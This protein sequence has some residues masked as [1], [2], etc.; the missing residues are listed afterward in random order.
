MDGIAPEMP[1]PAEAKWLRKT[2]KLLLLGVVAY[3]AWQ[4]RESFE[5]KA[6]VVYGPDHEQPTTLEEVPMVEQ[7][8]NLIRHHAPMLADAMFEPVKPVEPPLPVVPTLLRFETSLTIGTKFTMSQSF[9]CDGEHFEHCK[10]A[11][12]SINAMIEELYS[13]VDDA[14]SIP[15]EVLWQA[16]Y[17]RTI[18]AVSSISYWLA[19]VFLGC[20]GLLLS[21][22][23]F[24]LMIV[25]SQ[26][27][28]A[29]LTIWVTYL[30]IR[31]MI[32]VS[33]W[34][35]KC[36][37]RKSVPTYQ[38]AFF[39]PNAI[40][41]LFGQGRP[42]TRE[43]IH[44]GLCEWAMVETP[45]GYYLRPLHEIMLSLHKMLPVEQQ[46]TPP[47]EVI[48]AGQWKIARF[49]ESIPE[50]LAAWLKQDVEESVLQLM[51]PQYIGHR[52]FARSATPLDRAQIMSPY[53]DDSDWTTFVKMVK[54]NFFGATQDS[55]EIRCPLV[56]RSGLE[57]AVRKFGRTFQSDRFPRDLTPEE[58][59]LAAM[60]WFIVRDAESELT[61]NKR[62]KR[63]A[64]A[65][66]KTT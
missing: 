54:S 31:L 15:V 47:V 65:D 60:I 18:E 6:S 46:Q 42:L 26:L 30:A 23:Y 40:Q 13:R 41:P 39:D 51:A 10:H 22:L 14:T 50:R 37:L 3:F 17:S 48:I 4:Y 61:S 36:S 16:A 11:H 45:R 58:R 64:W 35:A 57:S 28:L 27:F 33:L 21:P 63:Y 5:F 59:Y 34:P 19:Q 8:K 38:A 29:L 9:L 53:V 62:E 2:V 32:G 43:E 1:P 66:F 12:E 52:H 44:N 24:L 56:N 20:V 7:M 55:N 25:T 49:I